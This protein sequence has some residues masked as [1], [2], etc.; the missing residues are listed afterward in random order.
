M[1]QLH[2]TILIAALAGSLTVLP[3]AAAASGPRECDVDPNV[4][5]P[6]NPEPI[7]QRPIDQ[8]ASNGNQAVGGSSGQPPAYEAPTRRSQAVRASSQATAAGSTAT[9]EGTEAAAPAADP[10]Q[11]EGSEA[12]SQAVA[13]PETPT[14]ALA[15][16]ASAPVTV[17]GS[18]TQRHATPMLMLFA[19]LLA[20]LSGMGLMAYSE[21]RARRSAGR[22]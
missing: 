4:Q 17:A 10:A 18:S 9:A 13:N 7:D 6:S 20:A 3:G 2:L 15:Q 21:Q 8:S 5:C 19:A 12:G 14:V 22:A 1:K 16:P 11:A